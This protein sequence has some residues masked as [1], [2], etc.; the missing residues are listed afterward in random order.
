MPAKWPSALTASKL[1]IAIFFIKF[2]GAVGFELV[3]E[4]EHERDIS[5]EDKDFVLAQGEGDSFS[6]DTEGNDM[7][8][9]AIVPGDMTHGP[10]RVF[11]P[12][13]MFHTGTN[14]M[15]ELLE[16]N[17][18]YR[19]HQ[20][21]PVGGAPWPDVARHPFWKHTNPYHIA[22]SLRSM[23]DGQDQKCRKWA[24]S[25]NVSEQ[26]FLVSVRNPFAQ[27]A[28]W[29]QKPYDLLH[30]CTGNDALF[31]ECTCLRGHIPKD[32][33]CCDADD[34]C[35][36]NHSA[37][38]SLAQVWNSYVRGYTEA[39][40]NVYVVRYE[41][42]VLDTSKVLAEVGKRLGLKRTHQSWRVR[43]PSLRLRR[44]I[45]RKQYLRHFTA[46]DISAV[47]SQL[48]AKLLHQ[49]GYDDCK[50]EYSGRAFAGSGFPRGGRWRWPRRRG[51]L[52]VGRHGAGSHQSGAA[53]L[54]RCGGASHAAWAALLAAALSLRV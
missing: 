15:A 12:L 14:W 8:N 46:Q 25:V 34:M 44:H 41:D 39:L 11:G 32:C 27:I 42:L 16:D 52:V 54:A 1:Y 5:Y 49:Q 4:I 19:T 13:G 37:P 31:A 47:C 40:P 7:C 24:S 6:E 36:Q 18:D 22:R 35:D 29:L 53:P 38:Q 43:K 10:I 21:H 33:A 9:M 51:A 50:P 2:G 3:S 17:F 28:A 30:N 45:S 26:I 20:G 48:D 23:L